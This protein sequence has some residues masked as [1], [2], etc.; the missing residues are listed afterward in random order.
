MDRK[1]SDRT[2]EA[3]FILLR[4][5]LDEKDIEHPLILS[6]KEWEDLLS[7][8]AVQTVSGMTARGIAHLPAG[9]E[10]PD[11]VLMKFMKKTD[12]IARASSKITEVRSK[13]ES[14]FRAYGLV[15]VIMK[16]PESASFYLRPELRECGDLDIYFPEPAFSKAC[17]IISS[18]GIAIDT[19]P[20]GSV[21]YM[22]EGIEIDQHNRYYDLHS[23]NLPEVPGPYATLLMLS[24]HIL[25]HCMTAG[26]GLRQ[27]CDMAMAYRALSGT[28]D[29]D[30]LKETYRK[31][32]LGRWNRLLAA[33]LE[34]HLGCT[35]HPYVH[36][37]LPDPSPLMAI[38]MEGGNFGHHAEGREKA[39]KGS[40]YA[41]KKD[42]V[43]RIL[44]RL[45]FSLR[46]GSKEL[47]RYVLELVRGN[48]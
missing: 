18:M 44:K 29:N 46:Y 2:I 35:S 14:S 20:D 1:W 3:L 12:S 13:L 23:R 40:P 48:L 10:I 32:G 28:L 4:A 21:R 43:K 16:G 22:F 24:S 39:E 33:F 5:G 26:V 17:D 42:T 45:P 19:A 47:F 38:I 6:D 30:M 31:A 9:N 25:K 15:P 11:M 41:R 36:E 34:K 27:L 8:S 7:L 37:T